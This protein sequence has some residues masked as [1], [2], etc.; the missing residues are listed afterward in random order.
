MTET[1]KRLILLVVATSIFLLIIPA[2]Y[3][4][5]LK[6]EAE[7]LAEKL[8]RQMLDAGGTEILEK[9]KK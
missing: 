6:M 3:G 1:K 5:G 7:E 2:L 9:L 4:Q 8:A